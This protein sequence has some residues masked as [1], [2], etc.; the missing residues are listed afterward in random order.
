MFE[1]TRKVQMNYQLALQFPSEAFDNEN[2]VSKFEQD[3][4]D[5]LGDDAYVDGVDRGVSET[6]VFVFSANPGITFQR[7]TPLLARKELLE[8]VTAA[9]RQSDG[10]SYTVIWPEG[11]RK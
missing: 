4:I 9:H 5:V 2:A 10:E 11:W 3:L 1:A 8:S 7:V 6:T